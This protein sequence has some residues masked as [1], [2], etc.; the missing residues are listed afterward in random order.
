MQV[1]THRIYTL[2][3]DVWEPLEEQVEKE[4]D[5]AIGAIKTYLSH[6]GNV[7]VTKT[8]EVRNA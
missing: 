6:A 8:L 7:K 1:I 5:S 4:I 3:L 2:E